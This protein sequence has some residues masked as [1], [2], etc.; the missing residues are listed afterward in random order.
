MRSSAV[1]LAC[2]AALALFAQPVSAQGTTCAACVLVQVLADQVAMLANV[3]VSFPNPEDVCHLD[4]EVCDGTC[5]L[6][7][8]TWPLPSPVWPSDGG[9]VDDRR[10][11]SAEVSPAS[12]WEGGAV[13]TRASLVR[14]LAIVEREEQMRGSPIP[15]T[16]LVTVSTRYLLQST[17]GPTLSPPCDGGLDISC[18]IDRVFNKHLPFADDDGD[19]HAP[20]VAGLLQDHLRG[21]DW[22]GRDCNDTDASIYPGRATS[23]YGAAI[24][25][26]CNGIAG[27]DPSS[28]TA[29]E[30][31]FCSGDNAP[32]GL[33][34]LGDSAAAHFH[35]PQQ[36]L[37]ARSFNLSGLLELAANEADWP[38][39]S[40]SSGFRDQSACPFM[41]SASRLNITY[42]S[43]YQRLWEL[44]HCNHRDYANLGVNGARTGS[45]APPGGIIEGFNRD[46]L[47]DAPALVFYALIGNDVCDGH[48]GNG[49]WTTVEEFYS[50]VIASLN[51]L[52][53][54]LPKGSHVAF[55]PLADGRVLFDTTH[56]QTHP[57]GVQYP[58]VYE[59]L[60]C[61]GITPCWGWLNPDEYWRNATTVRAQELTAVYA[62][63]IANASAYRYSF[64][65]HLVQL[66]WP[67][68]IAQYVAAG[69]DAMDIVEP[70]DGFHPSQTGNALL[71]QVIWEDLQANTN[72]LPKPNPFN[73][74]IE[75]LFGNQNGY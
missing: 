4:L 1:L 59:Y 70:V 39:C 65:M 46:P 33:V 48:P 18:D 58:A 73:A 9:V 2:A 14:F 31:L 43:I 63:I 35:L 40:W 22:R 52:N 19:N 5:S 66:N 51:Y 74:Q 3:S 17:L 44:N 29:Y 41:P 57:I 37:N 25:H 47:N 23:S 55:I 16:E 8:G 50:N 72:W 53:A 7:N 28:G 42:A 54:T 15:L 64:D 10:R 12:T 36:Y 20:P 32:M 75:Q 34:I 69:G 62:Q 24:D 6:L 60:I 49:S 26:N 56:E 38:Q 45:M 11:L 27:V 68:L 30:D 71:S 67:A 13:L 61:N 21:A